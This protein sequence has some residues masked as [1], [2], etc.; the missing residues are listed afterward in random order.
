M[1]KIVIGVSALLLGFIIGAIGAE[2]EVIETEKVVEVEKEVL[3]EDTKSLQVL[4]ATEE[5]NDTLV[6]GL[7][8]SI[9][10]LA[11]YDNINDRDIDTLYNILEIIGGQQ[12]K[13]EQM[14][15]TN[16]N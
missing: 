8:M 7:E 4:Q 10:M 3:I 9:A 11:D 16:Y 2:P 1:E 6:D 13:I 14:K 5:L 15:N 12:E